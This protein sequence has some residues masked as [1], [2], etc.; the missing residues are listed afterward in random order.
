MKILLQKY[1][2][3]PPTQ[4]FKI[5]LREFLQKHKG[6]G[7]ISQIRLWA[8]NEKLFTGFIYSSQYTIEVMFHNPG[9]F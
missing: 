3:A 8:L 9:N 1:E 2:I 7:A 6:L 4:E 5:L